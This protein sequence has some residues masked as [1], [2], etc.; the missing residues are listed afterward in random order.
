MQL[1]VFNPND[2]NEPNDDNLIGEG[3]QGVVYKLQEVKTQKIYAVK[4]LED[5]ELL[6]SEMNAI[7]KLNYPTL[8]HLYGIILQPCYLIMDY[9]QNKTVQNLIDKVYEG[10]ELN[11]QELLHWDLTHKLIIILG[12]SFGM[13]YLHS[14]NIVHRD[15][16]PGNVLLDLNFYPKICDFGLAKDISGSTTMTSNIG[17]PLFAA[18]EQLSDSQYDG[19][20]AD[21]YSFGM[22]LYSILHDQLPFA[23]EELN[24]FS[25]YDKIKAKER[26]KIEQGKISKFMEE[27]LVRCWNEDPDLRPSFEDISRELLKEKERLIENKEINE[28]GIKEIHEFIAGFCKRNDMESNPSYQIEMNKFEM[29]YK[30]NFNYK[31]DPNGFSPLH[32]AAMNNLKEV[33]E[34]FLSKGANINAKDLNF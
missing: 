28:E 12:I 3:A 30:E 20:K 19:K 7:L 18:P 24:T 27:L 2:F 34:V 6:I 26:P 8:I 16:K 10:E 11:N 14:M 23:N 4:I 15:L 31:N 5:P 1:K 33:L 21:V 32:Y 22:T 9:C 25:L 29:G 17:T 13:E